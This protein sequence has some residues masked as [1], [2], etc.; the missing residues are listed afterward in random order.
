MATNSHLCPGCGYPSSMKDLFCAACGARLTERACRSCGSPLGPQSRFCRACGVSA[1]AQE[2]KTDG[3]QAKPLILALQLV[4]SGSEPESVLDASTKSLQCGLSSAHAALAS[5]LSMWS[6]AHLGRFDEARAA[7]IKVREFYAS[8]LGLRGDLLSQYLNIPVFSDGLW[9]IGNAEAVRNPWFYFVLGYMGGPPRLTSEDLGETGPKRRAELLEMWRDF[10]N[11]PMP[12][13]G[14]LAYLLYEASKYSEAISILESICLIARKYEF[15]SPVRIELAWPHVILGECYW[16]LNAKEK[17]S[18][19]WKTVRSIELCVDSESQTDEWNK[20]ALPWI[21]RA[22][23]KLADNRVPLPDRE[24]TMKASAHLTQAMKCLI[25]ADKLETGDVELSELLSVI[26]GAGEKYVD[27]VNSAATH[28]DAAEQLDAFVW[29]TNAYHDHPSWYR[30]E[31]VKGFLFQ[32]KALINLTNDRLAVAAANYKM[33][34]DVWPMLSAFLAMAELQESCGLVSDAKA[35][36]RVCVDRFEELTA[37]ESAP[38][39]DEFQRQIDSAISA[40]G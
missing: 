1:D 39:H 2:I 22:K 16:A 38:D 36:Y 8:H 26:R 32:K 25:E 18:R 27:L 17:A 23:S 28:I 40:L 13:R 24:A 9:E 19:E 37:V 3:N 20:L 29:S 31:C 11:N 6:L 7:L 5:V 12:L 21:E 30:L 34:N 4:L 14:A 35:S 33:A 10:L 15:M